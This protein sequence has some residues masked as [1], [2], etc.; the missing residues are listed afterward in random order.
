MNDAADVPVLI[1]DDQAAFRSA[2]RTVVSLLAGFAV[3]A[4]TWLGNVPALR[5][6]DSE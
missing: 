2:A 3:A 6:D 5:R 4:C 1:V